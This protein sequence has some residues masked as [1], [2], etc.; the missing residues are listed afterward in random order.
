MKIIGI[1]I[2]II[3]ASC[4]IEATEW[5]PL[6]PLKNYSGYDLDPK[7]SISVM[8][9][10]KYEVDRN[11]K[12]HSKHYSIPV[13]MYSCSYSKIPKNIMSRFRDIKPNLSKDGDI[14]GNKKGG[15]LY[16]AFMLTY[17]NK[18]I[19]YMNE[20][21]DVVDF[22]GDINTPAEV[23][24]ILWL[25][26]KYRGYRYKITPQGYEVLIRHFKNGKCDK[27]DKYMTQ[28]KYQERAIVNSKGKIISYKLI[29]KKAS[30][31]KCDLDREYLSFQD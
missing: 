25:N 8:E 27:K 20:I 7:K 28:T 12:R 1:F 31:V 5:K 6:Y 9:I 26:G 2:V 22:L 23:Q 11:N 13:R 10:R 30:Q 17:D 18:N 3:L 16:N 15:S 29:D 21:S 24:L 19:Y 4:H 14:R